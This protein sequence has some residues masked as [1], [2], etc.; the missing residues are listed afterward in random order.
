[1]KGIINATQ[2]GHGSTVQP[3]FQQNACNYS[4]EKCS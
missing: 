4:L 1:M 3:T 2:E